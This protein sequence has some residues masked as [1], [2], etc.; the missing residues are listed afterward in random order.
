MNIL[1]FIQLAKEMRTARSRCRSGWRSWKTAVTTP[2]TGAGMMT[3]LI[4]S[5]CLDAVMVRRPTG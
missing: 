5:K 1:D 4:Q 2:K 3:R